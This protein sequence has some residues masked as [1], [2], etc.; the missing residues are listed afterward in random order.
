M[1]IY[2]PNFLSHIHQLSI[3]KSIDLS[4]MTLEQH[5]YAINRY[6]T[7]LPKTHPAYLFHTP[8]MV[9]KIANILHLPKLVPAPHPI[10]LRLYPPGSQMLFHKDESYQHNRTFELVYTI[11]NTSDSKFVWKKNGV[12]ELTPKNNS[13]IIVESEDIEH[14]VTPVTQGYRLILKVSYILPA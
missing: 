4:K 13:I 5:S 8:F 9:Q 6:I 11:Y 10:E 12:H 14:A 7:E 3:K 2:Q 1:L